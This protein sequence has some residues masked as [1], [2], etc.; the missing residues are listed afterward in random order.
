MV[1]LP[2]TKVEERRSDELFMTAERRS[3]FTMGREPPSDMEVDE[4]ERR[5]F[6]LLVQ[7]NMNA[8]TTA[9]G[10]VTRD[11]AVESGR[12][13]AERASVVGTRVLVGRSVG[14]VPGSGRVFQSC[15]DF[16][17]MPA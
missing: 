13:A 11:Q 15:C 3:A 2:D 6:M 16:V 8:R 5:D 9:L 14:V 12:R 10:R 17:V 4:S 1:S 7:Q